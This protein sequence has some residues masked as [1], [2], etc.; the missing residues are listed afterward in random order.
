[1]SILSIGR[2]IFHAVGADIKFSRKLDVINNPAHHFLYIV[3]N[4]SFFILLI[5]FILF[6]LTL[7]FENAPY[8]REMIINLDIAQESDFLNKKIKIFY[9]ICVPISL[10]ISF[11]IAAFYRYNLRNEVEYKNLM[12]AMHTSNNVFLAFFYF[13]ISLIYLSVLFVGGFLI[14]FVI[15]AA[16]NVSSGTFLSIFQ[17][18]ITIKI[19][20]LFCGGLASA[21]LQCFLT[22]SKKFNSVQ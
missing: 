5:V 21:F 19:F 3:N 7:K 9:L 10:L 1:M 22:F 15:P 17:L 11:I 4:I 18:F 16:V 13:I 20:A 6:I 12:L 8:L 14:A 2:K